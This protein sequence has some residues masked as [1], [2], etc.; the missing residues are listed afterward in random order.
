MGKEYCKVLG[1]NRSA[2]D[3]D[4]RRAYRKL[5]LGRHP[6]KNKAPDAEE[7]FK[8]ISE[9]Y[10]AAADRKGRRAHYSS[11]GEGYRSGYPSSS[12][13]R[14]TCS[15]SHHAKGDHPAR[16]AEFCATSRRRSDPGNA[17]QR[18]FGAGGAAADL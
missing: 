16:Y 15:L 7:K 17:Y 3:E 14:E 13:G 8:E 1:P 4:I 11:G 18:A 2:G 6:D 12:G 10:G 9:A 5:A